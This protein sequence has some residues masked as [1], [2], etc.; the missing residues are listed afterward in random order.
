MGQLTAPQHYAP[1]PCPVAAGLAQAESWH[2][3]VAQA[4][5]ILGIVVQEIDRHVQG[6]FANS[7]LDTY[8]IEDAAN[9]INETLDKDGNL[10]KA[11]KALRKEMNRIQ[12]GDL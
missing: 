2:R 3:R 6:Q 11:L 1:G 9:K 12:D 5:D 4:C 10:D 8:Y 7:N